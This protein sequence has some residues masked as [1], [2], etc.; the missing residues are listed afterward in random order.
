MMYE[1]GK[2][3]VTRLDILPQRNVGASPQTPLY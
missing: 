2:D 3:S 1:M